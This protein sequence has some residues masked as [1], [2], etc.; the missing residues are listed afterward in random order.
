[1][2]LITKT[3]ILPR[4]GKVRI[5]FYRDRRKSTKDKTTFS[6]PFDIHLNEEIAVGEIIYSSVF[7]S[8]RIMWNEPPDDQN[9]IE[10]TEGFIKEFLF[11]T[12]MAMTE[13]ID[14]NEADEII[15]KFKEIFWSSIQYT[16]TSD[17]ACVLMIP[18]TG[19][20]SRQLK[21]IIRRKD[22]GDYFLTDDGLI[23]RSFRPHE[24]GQREKVVFGAKKLGIEVREEELIFDSNAEELPEK[25]Y[26]FIQFVSAVYLFYLI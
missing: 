17:G 19:K 11:G 26:K 3:V 18:I 12:L 13:P 7:R 6:L 21:I 16:I 2:N 8:C 23:L 14:R 20:A 1:M 24:R 4:T 25:L 10:E 5:T 22:T 15:N 9:I